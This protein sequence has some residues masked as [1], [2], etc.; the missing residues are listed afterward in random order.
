MAHVG[1]IRRFRI[2]METKTPRDP[3]ITSPLLTPQERLK[4]WQHFKGML[5]SCTPDLVEELEKM[6]QEWDRELFTQPRSASPFTYHPGY[7]RGRRD[8]P[9]SKRLDV[10]YE[11][12]VLP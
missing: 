4:L 5:K 2:K 3:L 11:N 6:R 8:Q 9:M 10:I 7:T 1:I 12:G